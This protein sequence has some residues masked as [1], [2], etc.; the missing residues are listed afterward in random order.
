MGKTLD[1]D[2]FAS[3]LLGSLPPSYSPTIGGINAAADST[4]NA[5]TS[6]QVIQLISDKYDR[7]TIHK[8][9]N[10]PDE[11]FS[12]TTQK[13]HDKRNVKCYNCHKMGHYKSDCWAKGGDKE[14]QRPSRRNDSDSSNDNY[15]NRN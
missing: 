8:N 10:G 4:G 9:K 12:T 3:I 5:I 2:E 1:D 11:A 14:G 6:N 15:G 7:H 13:Q